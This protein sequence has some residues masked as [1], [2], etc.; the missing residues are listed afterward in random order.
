LPLFTGP[1]GLPV[2]VQVVAR[3]NADRR[4][5]TAAQWVCRASG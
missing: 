4:L 1:N 3:R 2:G 5:F